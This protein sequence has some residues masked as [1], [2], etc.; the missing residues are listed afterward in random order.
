VRRR[1]DKALGERE[2]RQRVPPLLDRLFEKAP[3][4]VDPGVG[5]ELEAVR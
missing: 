3:G 2:R 1:I 4:L 5:L